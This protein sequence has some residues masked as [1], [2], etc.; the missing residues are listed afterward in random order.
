MRARHLEHLIAVIVIGL[1]AL[2]G[3]KKEGAGGDQ[4]PGKAAPGSA[5]TKAA[6]KPAT[7]AWTEAPTLEMI[8]AGAVKGEAQG[9]PFEPK[10]IVIEPAEKTW[11]LLLVEDA[12]TKPDEVWPKGQVISIE[13]PEDPAPGKKWTRAMS[14]A[15]GSFQ[16]RQPGDP[17]KLTG[18]TGFNAWVMEITGWEVKPYEPKGASYQLAGKA[19]GRL[20]IC[21]QKSGDYQNAWA[22]GELKD[23][24]VRYMGK[25]YFVK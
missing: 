6:P 2:A 22:A 15:G 16:I 23:V 9:K 5:A 12:L 1:L 17:T 24:P 25:P 13:L 20:A 4:P 10:A 7:F 19:S 18:W 11:R 14:P 3:C 21:Y 8:P